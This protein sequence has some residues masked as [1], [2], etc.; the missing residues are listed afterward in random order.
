MSAWKAFGIVVASGPLAMGFVVIALGVLVSRLL[1]RQHPAWRAIARVGFLIILTVLLLQAGV[2]P[3]Q[4][5]QS[6]GVPFRD[7]IVGILKVTWWLWGAWFLVALISSIV[8]FESRPREGKLLR[9]LLSALTYLAAV[10]A[11]I[12]YVFDLP[13]QGLLATSGA[14]AIIL[15]LALQSTLNDVFSGL[16]LSFS[17]P[18]RPG[19]WISIDGGTEGQVVEM[20]WRA[21]HVLT[22]RHDLA[23]LPNST[24]SK[25]KIVNL[26]FPSGIHGI[27]VTVRLACSPAPGIAILEMALLN[28][29][30]ILTV[31]QP[32]IRVA[33]IEDAKTEFE[34]TAFVEHVG[35]AI[36]AQNE[37]FDLIYRHAAATGIR[38]AA[39][40][41]LPVLAR[42]RDDTMAA[43]SNA[44]R[45][46]D[47]IPLFHTL[48]LE[49]RAALA[50]SLKQ[51]S[52]EP[53]ALVVQRGVVLTSLFLVGRGVLSA[54]VL[55]N[56]AEIEVLRF[57]PGDHYGEIGLLTGTAASANITALAPSTVYELAR[58]DLARILEA[59]PQ[60][61]HELSHALT[62]R[63]AAGK[64]LIATGPD[65]NE[66]HGGLSNWFLE[67]IHRLL[68]LETAR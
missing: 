58:S 27:A 23:I 38:L 53:S 62:E 61:A 35:D 32:L 68:E 40:K 22:G 19:D 39:S 59:R 54:R 29:R 33:S 10:F 15:G 56:G 13:I 7:A 24:I 55:S 43:R 6:S 26:N 21:T 2:V 66:L 17:R 30:P 4:P 9:D 1:L 34:V 31:P 18:F 12:A 67:R 37:L 63:Q 44:E 46:L 60:I 64:A 11:I 50:K 3:Y 5:L 16:V 51:T 48:N 41:E 14:I 47:I 57:G 65:R 42:E 45:A 49:E 28:A 8:V 20:N 25:S 36:D 52:Y